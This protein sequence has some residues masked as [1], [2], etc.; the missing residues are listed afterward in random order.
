MSDNQIEI[1]SVTYAI[2]YLAAFMIGIDCGINAWV[3]LSTFSL[4]PIL[5]SVFFIVPIAIS[6]MTLNFI[7]YKRDFPE[8]FTNLYNSLVGNTN[9]E[10]SEEKLIFNIISELVAISSAI[11]MFSF[12]MNSYSILALPHVSTNIV[13]P[14]ILSGAYAIGT[15]G[16]LRKSIDADEI[17][18]NY[19]K[20]VKGNKTPVII[21]TGAL[22]TALLFATWFTIQAFKTG[23]INYFL[24]LGISSSVVIPLTSVL[25][26]FIWIGEACFAACAG[27]EVV[28]TFCEKN[29]LENSNL[30]ML[31]TMLFLSVLNAIGNGAI[32]ASDFKVWYR[33]TLGSLLSFCGMIKPSLDIS[34]IKLNNE[35]NHEE[36]KGI[37]LAIYATTILISLWV[38][39]ELIQPIFL[40][41][42]LL[43][44]TTYYM[45]ITTI[46]VLTSSICFSIEKNFVEINPVV[47]NDGEYGATPIAPTE[48]HLNQEETHQNRHDKRPGSN[49]D[50]LIFP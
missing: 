39:A 3:Y 27:I 40:A 20:L 43:N 26:C 45:F 4:L 8:E 36:N 49:N 37:R 35:E 44:S 32:T 5:G 30:A 17:G 10:I 50:P 47:N 23:A 42:L 18:G 48:K 19:N 46:L 1:N 15:Y 24:S 11:I 2:S 6:G 41:K 38:F 9:T 31:T 12:T 22:V 25:M 21:I 28:Q 16:L 34:E 33:I 14:L 13:Y 7:L 29:K